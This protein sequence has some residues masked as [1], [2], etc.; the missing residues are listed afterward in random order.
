MIVE[1]RQVG[2]MGYCDNCKK[3]AVVWAY[4]TLGLLCRECLEPLP[5]EPL[6]YLKPPHKRTVT[7][8]ELD[9]LLRRKEEIC[10]NL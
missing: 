2:G 10:Q 1:Q 4:S 6:G 8:E 5:M 3:L 7:Q 9:L